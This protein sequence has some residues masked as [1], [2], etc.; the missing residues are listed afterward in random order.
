MTDFL[1]DEDPG[2]ATPEV[3]V[4]P[5]PAITEAEWADLGRPSDPAPE[6]EAV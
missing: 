6:G 1:R 5:A 2:D 4:T 3:P